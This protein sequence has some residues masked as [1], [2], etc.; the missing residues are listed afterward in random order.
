MTSCAAWR[1]LIFVMKRPVKAFKAPRVH[2]AYLRIMG[3]NP[4]DWKNAQ[5]LLATVSREWTIARLWLRREMA[6][7]S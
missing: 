5:V 6:G 7:A 2:E 4:P 3:K 1:A